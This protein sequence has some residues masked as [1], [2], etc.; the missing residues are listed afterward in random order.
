MYC[1]FTQ[2]ALIDC[3]GFPFLYMRA[4]SSICTRSI[5]QQKKKNF[6]TNRW[7]RRRGSLLEAASGEVDGSS[8]WERRLAAGARGCRRRQQLAEAVAEEDG[9]SPTLQTSPHH[10]A[11]RHTTRN[12]EW[13]EL[14]SDRLLKQSSNWG[15]GAD[16]GNAVVGIQ[17]PSLSFTIGSP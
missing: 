8:L 10:V 5:Q 4:L 11:A 3:N 12:W 1:L 9:S 6:R 13:R 14:C 17:W 16:L 7:R 15:G 2:R